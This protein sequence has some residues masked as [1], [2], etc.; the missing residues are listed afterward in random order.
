LATY[1]QPTALSASCSAQPFPPPVEDTP[2]SVPL[3]TA[4]VD[5]PQRWR[6]LRDEIP[7]PAQNPFL[8]LRLGRRQRDG[9]IPGRGRTAV[10]H[11][12]DEDRPTDHARPTAALRHHGDAGD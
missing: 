2:R 10:E 8:F 9:V 7:E 5:A 3:S 12:G 11:R 6:E 4:V 1:L